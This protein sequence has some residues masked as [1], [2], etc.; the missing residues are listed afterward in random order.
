MSRL[1]RPPS[2]EPAAN[3]TDAPTHLPVGGTFETKLWRIHRYSD[4]VRMT[5]LLHA[6][7][8]GKKCLEITVRTTYGQGRDVLD[9]LVSH[10]LG[11]V[12]DDPSAETLAAIARD[13]PLMSSLLQTTVAERR[14]V[15]VETHVIR[16]DSDLVQAHFSPQE[17]RITVTE[18]HGGPR[19][20]FR[21]DTHL[22]NRDKRSAAIGYAFARANAARIATMTRT[23]IYTALREAGA[24]VDTWG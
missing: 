17:F 12:V 2:S 15:D 19:G 16:I 7:V 5:H 6:G 18:V 20:A 22:Y 24:R 1:P 8:R 14:G 3:D 13:A 23:E 11:V 10:L 21:Q 4:S 9:Q